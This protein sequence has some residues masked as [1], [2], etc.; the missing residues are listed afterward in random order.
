MKGGSTI[1]STVLLILVVL[2]LGAVFL[3]WSMVYWQKE[4][5]TIKS[6]SKEQTY[7]MQIVSITSNSI[8]LYNNGV[9]SIDVNKIYVYKDG[10]LVVGS[11]TGLL[12]PGD[13]MDINASIGTCNACR[14]VVTYEKFKTERVI[15]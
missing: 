8:R 14:I 1:I 11:N 4:F 15:K 12:R 2:E 10:A 3:I 5:T 13:E 7:S 9:D 6:A